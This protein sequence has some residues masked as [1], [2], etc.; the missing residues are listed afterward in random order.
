MGGGWGIWCKKQWLAC[1]V[2]PPGAQGSETQEAWWGVARQTWVLV[3]E[4]QFPLVSELLSSS[5]FSQ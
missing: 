5:V 2:F 3:S 4:P 1:L